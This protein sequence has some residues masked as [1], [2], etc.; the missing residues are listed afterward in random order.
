MCSWSDVTFSFWERTWASL[1]LRRLSYSLRM[2]R[3]DDFQVTLLVS[4]AVSMA[5]VIMVDISSRSRFAE[6]FLIWCDLV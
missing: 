5:W 6:S 4:I 1:M 3:M 2:S